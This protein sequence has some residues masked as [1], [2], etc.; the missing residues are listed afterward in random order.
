MRQW[1]DTGAKLGGT[2]ARI[3][4]RLRLAGAKMALEGKIEARCRPLAKF[5]RV[6]RT[7]RKLSAA[8]GKEALDDAVFERME[9][10][11][12][13]PAAGLQQPF[14]SMQR[15]DQ[16]IELGVHM[17]AQRLEGAGGGMNAV[18]RALAARW[19]AQRP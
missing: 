16:F 18:L 15:L 12:D 9:G 2:G 10:D 6:A 14:G 5:E 8:R 19:R 13:Q 17:D 1:C 7:M 11:D 3:D 4:P